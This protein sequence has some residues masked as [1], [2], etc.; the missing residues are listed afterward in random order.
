MKS[1][2]RLHFGVLMSSLDDP[3]QIR[4]L[5]G[6]IEY[7]RKHDINLTAYVAT[8]QT[9]GDES[10]SCIE[11][12]TQTIIR[13]ES[14]TGVV[15]FGGFIAHTIGYEVFEEYTNRI[16]E[17]LPV[18]MV[19]YTMEG[20][21]TVLADNVGGIANAVEHLIK[22]HGKRK[23]A[24]IKGPDGHPEAE[25]RLEGYIKALTENGIEVDESYI[26]PG[27]FS[28][29][30]GYEAA[31]EMFDVRSVFAE[32]IVT[33][34]DES[35]IGFVNELRSRG[36]VV[37]VD[38]AVAGFDDDRG[39]AV[40]IPSISTARQDF[41]ELG[42]AGAVLL[43]K[44]IRD[45]QVDGLNY[46]TPRFIARQ[47][48]GC[49]GRST[50]EEM[51]KSED[52]PMEKE[53]LITFVQGHFM[54]LFPNQ[55]PQSLV[56]EWAAEVIEEIKKSS[57][58][59]DSFLQLLDTILIVYSH[60]S[61][62]FDIWYKA[63]DI[64]TM[65]AE[66]QQGD[67][68]NAHLILSTLILART[69]VN[70]VCLREA[71]NREYEKYDA[72]LFLKRITNS[73]V[74]LFDIDSL[75]E[76]SYNSLPQFSINTIFI[77]LYHSSIKHSDPEA[78]RNIETLIGY[79]RDNKFN[80]KYSN[81]KLTNPNPIHFSD[82]STIEGFDF[83]SER[84]E[85]F[86]IP[87]FFKDEELGIMLL[88][89]IPEIPIDAYDTLRLN[90]TAAT[91]GAEL[92]STIRTLSV[93][94]ELTGLLNRRGFFQFA[95]SRLRHLHRS[96]D[97]IPILMF[98]D[99][100]GLKHINDTFGH[101]EGDVAIKAFAKIL[102]DTMREED[103]LGRM[104]GDE[105]VAFSSVKSDRNSELLVKRLRENINDYNLTNPHPY[106]VAGSIGC[107]ILEEAT[108]K[109]FDDAMITADSVLY[110]E[111]MEKKKKGLSRQ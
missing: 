36:I 70:D 15:I 84:R 34:D 72:Q 32:A 10:A 44:K 100:D 68:D 51:F 99:M 18:I 53:A 33:S 49:V 96:T 87:L 38:I 59:V 105:F 86:F 83:E 21:P 111:K 64:L 92:L 13:S 101:S 24:F 76:E 108:K 66:F 73:L 31:V 89:Y 35:A 40:S 26:F 48:C 14:L 17:R 2:K 22:V 63:L 103:I 54:P 62:D 58:N 45:E 85:F 20:I 107:V 79:D 71:K 80:I 41:F 81:I 94:D 57:F 1:E 46:V 91:K 4:I 11:A 52:I 77:G 8:Y 67:G 28:R 60:Y 50:P 82:Y 56:S 65:C 104:G 27:N 23:I 69:L 39:S 90:I 9:T 106:K 93:T 6:I 74:L 88:P 109:C 16:A 3:S 110:E 102:N 97:S 5:D 78:N 7:T 42:E 47:S 43:G 98:M 95:Y 30:G 37:P 55:V 19:S 12:C 75:A 29:E 25:E 61:S